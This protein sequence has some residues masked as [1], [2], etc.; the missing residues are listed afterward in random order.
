L[1]GHSAQTCTLISVLHGLR[2]VNI[3]ICNN[4]GAEV[5][6]VRTRYAVNGA[7]MPD[8]CPVCSPETFERFKS[9]R[10]GQISMGWEYN[11]TMYKKTDNGYIAKDE[12]IADTEAQV[13]KPDTEAEENYQRSLAK[14]RANRRTK[15]MTQAEIERALKVADTILNVQTETAVN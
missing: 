3:A 4:C 2:I 10:D 14:K 1:H 5:S 13:M 7:Q 8:E 9:V 11:H 12:L 15:P 6:R